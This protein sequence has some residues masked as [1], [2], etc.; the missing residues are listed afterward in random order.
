MPVRDPGT[1][2]DN[3]TPICQVGFSS[4]SIGCAGRASALCDQTGGLG[5]SGMQQDSEATGL[6]AGHRPGIS[7]ALPRLARD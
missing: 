5:L 4:S 7:T 2:H 6:V 3:S 1:D